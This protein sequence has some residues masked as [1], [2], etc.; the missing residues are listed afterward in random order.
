MTKYKQTKH[1]KRK[2]KT[3]SKFKFQILFWNRPM[4][5]KDQTN[6]TNKAILIANG[7]L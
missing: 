1:C 3:K 6:D 7:S 5:E 2:R 4:F